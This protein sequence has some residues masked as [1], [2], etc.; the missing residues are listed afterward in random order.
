MSWEKASPFRD[1]AN[2]PSAVAAFSKAAVL[3]QPAE[4][5]RFSDPGFSKNRPSVLAPEE[6]AGTIRD[7]RPYPAE[8]PMTNTFLGPFS[9]FG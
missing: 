7:A 5:V 8:A 4:P 9:I 3:Y 1:L 2:S 6:N